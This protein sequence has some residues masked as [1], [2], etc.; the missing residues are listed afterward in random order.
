MGKIVLIMKLLLIAMQRS[1]ENQCPGLKGSLF[2]LDSTDLSK[3]L[4]G[5]IVSGSDTSFQSFLCIDN[6]TATVI[7]QKINES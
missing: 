5:A 4:V 7:S 3:A 1:S 6:F 2:I